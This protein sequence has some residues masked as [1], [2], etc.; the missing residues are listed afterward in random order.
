MPGK[1]A[2]IKKSPAKKAADKAPEPAPEPEPAPAAE[3]PPAE[4][5]P[6]ETAPPEA[7]AAAAAEAAPPAEGEAVPA[8]PAEDAPAAEG[9][10]PAAAPAAEDG[11]AAPAADAPADAAPAEAAVVEEPPK[12]P[13]PPPPAV[14][15]SAPLDVSVDDVNDSSLTI[16]WKTPETIGDSGLDG[17]TIEYCKDGTTDWVV[18]NE[19]LTPANRYCIKNLTAGDL[20]HVRVVAVNPGGRS[21]PGALAEPVPI[22]EIVDRPKIRMPRIL[23]SRY[24]RQVGEQINLVIPFLGKP[25]PV[26]SW[27]KDGQP[28]DTKR[29]NIRNSDKDSIIFIRTAQREDS[30]VY[31]MAVKVDSFE[32]KA[33]LTL[34]IVELPGPPASV[35]LVDTWGFNAA[36]EWTPPKDNGNT[37][38]TGYTVQKADRKTGE[39]FTVLE[40]YHRLTATVSDLIMGNSY[41]FRVFA[42]NQ[43]GI[44]E[45]SAVTKEVA[46]IQKTG[47]VYK[48][49][50]YPEHDF[51]EAP[52]FTTT[53]NDRAAT[54]GYTTKL[55]CSVRGSPKP[56]IEW[57]KNQM[58]IGDDPKFRQLSNQGICSLEIRKPCSFD[59]GVYTCRAKNAQ[60]E[61]TVSCKLEVKL[62]LP[63]ADK[64]KGK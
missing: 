6:V 58:V 13:T 54:V 23:R 57:L 10:V 30:G 33:L 31:E 42:E 53:L 18:S 35:K 26:V 38:I 32:D 47:I 44:S 40:H 60:G 7:A 51:S 37:D 34:Q 56:K 63:E 9:S 20:L 50:E 36:L 15:T 39:W 64:E 19:Q 25:K 2:P 12:A 22:R 24:I 43:V 61:A 52:K 8:A 11:A 41:S 29:V 3:A 21:E 14:P 28:V 45:T 62:I 16:K 59:G 48:P 4:P 49:P 27:L 1:P 17:Y 55:L 5:A 46:T